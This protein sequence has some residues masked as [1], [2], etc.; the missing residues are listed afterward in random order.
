MYY[1]REKAKYGPNNPVRYTTTDCFFIKWVE[2]IH[3]QYKEYKN[4]KR[5]ITADHNVAKI[6][7][8]FK[9]IANIAW[10]RVDNVFIPVNLSEEYH[11]VL[12][13]LCMK[14]RCLYEY[15]SFPGGA[16]HTNS[17]REV[18]ERLAN[19]IPLFFN[20]TGF[21]GK[22]NDINW[23]TESAYVGKSFDD[24][25]E[26]VFVD[27]LPEQH[28]ESNDCGLYTCAF[29]EYISQ[30]LFEI[31]EDDFDAAL[32]R[33]RYG[34]LLWDYARKKQADGAISESEVTRNV[35]SRLGGPKICKEPVPERKKLPRLKRKV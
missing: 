6:I 33:R 31:F 4:D 28:L 10:N 1:L 23:M 2:A 27:N 16:M 35:I 9:L 15:D 32:H 17:I 5:F 18:I 21:Y 7:R 11:W 3:K 25:L 29:T 22:R 8:G 14:R 20:C 12:V 13:V 34:A 26:Y 19:M 24:P 30:G